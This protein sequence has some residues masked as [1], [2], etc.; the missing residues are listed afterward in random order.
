MYTRCLSEKSTVENLLEG[1]EYQ[2]H[3]IWY[4]RRELPIDSFF[5]EGS[6]REFYQNLDFSLV[7]T[8]TS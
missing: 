6:Y 1:Y 4:D 7:M 3:E 2:K 5:E 8:R